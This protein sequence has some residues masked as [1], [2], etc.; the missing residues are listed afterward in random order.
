[1]AKFPPYPIHPITDIPGKIAHGED[2]WLAI[3]SFLHDWWCYAVDYRHELI[4]TPPAVGNTS[5]EQ[6]WAAFYAATVEE[7]CK[8]TSFPTPSWVY[9][10]TYSLDDPWFLYDDSSQ[11]DWLLTTS[12]EP[13][14]QR[15]VFVGATILDNKYEIQPTTETK[16]RWQIWSEEEL[17]H[18]QRGA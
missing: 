13:F 12:P 18:Y 2:P 7:L 14:K 9:L 17:K 6:Q 5:T 10:S 1:M 15:N 16:P 11:R 3:G 8:R 4:D